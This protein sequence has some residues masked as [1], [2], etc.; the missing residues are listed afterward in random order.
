MYNRTIIEGSRASKK[1]S[2]SLVVNSTDSVLCDVSLLK[3]TCYPLD[4]VLK[5][6]LCGPFFMDGVQLLQG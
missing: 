1:T 2:F 4:L 5:K 6:K 3:F